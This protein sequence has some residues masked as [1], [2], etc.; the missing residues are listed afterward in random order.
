[1]T[2]KLSTRHVKSTVA[3]MQNK[4]IKG[5][6]MIDDGQSLIE[7]ANNLEKMLTDNGV[8]EAQIEAIIKEKALKG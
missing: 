4:R 3:E 7:V 5:K 1:M 2:Q 8:T 6:Q